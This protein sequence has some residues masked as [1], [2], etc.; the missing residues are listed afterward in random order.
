MTD[1]EYEVKVKVLEVKDKIAKV[2]PIDDDGNE[3]GAVF[4]YSEGKS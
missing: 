2:V 1:E 3:I 4:Y